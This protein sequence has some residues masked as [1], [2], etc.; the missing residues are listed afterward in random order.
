MDL[1]AA[2]HFRDFYFE[3]PKPVG[4]S[5]RGGASL[6]PAILISLKAYL[7]YKNNPAFFSV[8]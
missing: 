5:T 4:L 1:Y 2:L 7:R 3:Q 6:Q 8:E